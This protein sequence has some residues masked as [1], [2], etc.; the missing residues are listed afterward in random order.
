[1]SDRA[2]GLDA[3]LDALRHADRRTVLRAL[4]RADRRGETPVDIDR[5]TAGDGN[6]G[7]RL[8]HVHLPKL[9]DLGFV[10]ANRDR[11]HV[12]VGPAFDEIEPWLEFFD[13]NRDELSAD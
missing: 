8:H 13:E 10:R 4:L 3:Q 2:T 1:M 6:R 7:I 9:E 5:L 12:T 11:G